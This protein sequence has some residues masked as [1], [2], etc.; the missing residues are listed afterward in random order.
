MSS[1]IHRGWTRMA[2]SWLVERHRDSAGGS[3]RQG[4]AGAANLMGTYIARRLL[5][6]IPTLVGITFLVFMLVAVTPGGIAASAG[7]ASAEAGRGGQALA[8]AYFEDRYGLDDPALVQ[9]ARWLRRV[10]PLK[11]GAA[12]RIAPDGELIQMPRPIPDPAAW[13]W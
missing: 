1:R 9:Y 6:M 3:E 4:R 5:L 10:S 2:G 8:R 7:A 13:R 12:D 11:F